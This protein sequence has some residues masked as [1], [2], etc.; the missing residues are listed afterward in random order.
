MG[1]LDS[2]KDR[3]TQ[4]VEVWHLA[5]EFLSLFSYDGEISIELTPGHP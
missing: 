4:I 3:R 5:K 1:S 2:S